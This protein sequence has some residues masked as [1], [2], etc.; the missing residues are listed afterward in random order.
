MFFNFFFSPMSE[1]QLKRVI[2]DLLT[3]HYLSDLEDNPDDIAAQKI[4][5][6]LP[7]VFQDF[8]N[9]I[10]QQVANDTVNMNEF[11]YFFLMLF[12]QYMK[13]AI[14]VMHDE[15]LFKK[16]IAERGK[17]LNTENYRRIV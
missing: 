14:D 6:A 13:P 5:K 16:R 17:Y 11:S 7:I 2:N 3:Q 9:P 4:L 8:F 15:A 10:Y 12:G 1:V